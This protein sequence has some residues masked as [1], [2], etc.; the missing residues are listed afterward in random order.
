MKW[1]LAGLVVG[2]LIGSPSAACAV[3]FRS[4]SV[5]WQTNVCDI[6]AIAE[7]VKTSEIELAD[8]PTKTSP[9][10]KYWRS[11]TVACKITKVLKGR[12]GDSLNLRQDYSR[13]Q[14]DPPN[15]DRPLR[16]GDKILTFAVEK[17]APWHEKVIFWVNLTKPDVV[18]AQHAAYNSDCKWLADSDSILKTVL[19]RID[20]AR[21]TGKTRQRGVIVEFTAGPPDDLYLGFVRTADSDYKATLIKQLHDSRYPDDKESAIYNLVSYPG[22]DTI[23]LIRP[24]LKDANTKEV[25]SSGRTVRVFHLRLA[26]YAALQL[27]GANPAKPEGFRPGRPIGLWW[28]TGF[29]ARVYFPYGDWQRIE[30]N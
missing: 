29:E 3:W 16:P 26:A 10:R 4:E 7:I 21:K 30:T 13:V 18:K 1:T 27:L 17:P 6:V 14:K 24:F 22:Q 2:L 20:L 15:D 25:G 28:D 23:N 12:H 11:Q 9:S 8:Q 5:E 19:A